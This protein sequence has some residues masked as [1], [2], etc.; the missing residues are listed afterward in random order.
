MRKK[1]KRSR[2]IQ[3]EKEVRIKTQEERELKIKNEITEEWIKEVTDIKIRN[4]CMANII[5]ANPVVYDTEDTKKE[6]FKQ[7]L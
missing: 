4:L 7:W 6:Q 3:K 1:S 5:M 2:K